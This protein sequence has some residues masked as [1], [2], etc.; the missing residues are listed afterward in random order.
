MFQIHNELLLTGNRYIIIRLIEHGQHGQRETTSL[1]ILLIKATN[2]V[3]G[4]TSI[5][6]DT[7]K[8]IEPLQCHVSIQTSV[9]SFKLID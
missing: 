3:I 5:V 7:H 2:T 6:V 4:G 1:N 8:Q 9:Y